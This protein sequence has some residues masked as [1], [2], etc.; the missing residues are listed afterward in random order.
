MTGLQHNYHTGNLGES[1]LHLTSSPESNPRTATCAVVKGVG[2]PEDGTQNGVPKMSELAHRES[3]I[4]NMGLWNVNKGRG[5]RI[6][7]RVIR[8]VDCGM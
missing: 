3:R 6:G 8:L 1:P 2:K 5:M 7:D 4:V